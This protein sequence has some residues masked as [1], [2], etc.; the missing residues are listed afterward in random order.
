MISRNFVCV[1]LLR[2]S[3]KR[4]CFKITCNFWFR[5]SSIKLVLFGVYVRVTRCGS[6]V[7]TAGAT[8]CGF[9]D[10]VGLMSSILSPIDT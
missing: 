6:V 1:M 5:F 9:D 8:R 2:C 4:S 3:A 10:V 7:L